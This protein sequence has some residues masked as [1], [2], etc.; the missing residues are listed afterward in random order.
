MKVI[1]DRNRISTKR[2]HYLHEEILEAKKEL[3]KKNLN[4]VLLEEEFYIE[5]L[6]IPKCR[7]KYIDAVVQSEVNNKFK[8]KDDILY[9][10]SIVYKGKENIKILINY[11]DSKNI[12][13]LKHLKKVL[14]ISSVYPVQILESKKIKRKLRKNIFVAIF[15]Y[16][17]VL[18]GFTYY[19]KL[20]LGTI[21]IRKDD[22]F[23]KTK[24]KIIELMTLSNDI[25]K[26]LNKEIPNEIYFFKDSINFIKINVNSIYNEL[27]KIWSECY[28]LQV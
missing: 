17:D 10:Y 23:E 5:C 21:I 7:K 9:N 1:I 27:K 12:N 26:Q 4:V 14:K 2:N 8:E 19:K 25:I 22:S 6:T 18:Y 15:P 28:E 24:D 16:E 3:Q 11:I 20:I 13:C